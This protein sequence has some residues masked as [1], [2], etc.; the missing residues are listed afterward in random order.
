MKK[1]S[2]IMEAMERKI[3]SI[4]LGKPVRL[5]E[6][7]SDN[8]KPEYIKAAKM[9]LAKYGVEYLKEGERDE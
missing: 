6:I 4:P 7:V 9:L 5:S 1:D 3:E 8:E 2:T